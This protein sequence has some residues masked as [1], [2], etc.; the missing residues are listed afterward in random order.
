MTRTC[1]LVTGLIG[2]FLALAGCQSGGTDPG[3]GPDGG[4]TPDASAIRDGLASLFAG[5]HPGSRENAEGACFADRLT[6]ATAERS[7][8]S[9]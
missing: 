6:A 7:G 2:L 1:L 9:G 5:D 3:G 8:V 4:A